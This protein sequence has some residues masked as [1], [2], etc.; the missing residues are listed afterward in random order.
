[1]DKVSVGPV[2]INLTNSLRMQRSWK[3]DRWEVYIMDGWEESRNL[4][5]RKIDRNFID[6]EAVALLF[7][8]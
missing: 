2:L 5:R 6:E 8:T 3:S 1:M 4:V 7:L